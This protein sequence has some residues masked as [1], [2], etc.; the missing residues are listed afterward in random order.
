I[1]VLVIFN[2]FLNLAPGSDPED[3]ALGPPQLNVTCDCYLNTLFLGGILVVALSAGSSIF[4]SRLELYFIGGLAFATVTIAG[5]LGRRK[6]HS[7]WR[8]DEKV[9]RRAISKSNIMTGSQR[10][11]DIV[12]DEED[13]EDFD[14]ENY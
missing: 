1:F 8:E 4:S 3:F 11:V 10:S 13:D 6:R 5:I 7:E 2:Y 14:F 12:F 9:I